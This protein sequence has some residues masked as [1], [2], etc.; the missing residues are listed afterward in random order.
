MMKKLTSGMLAAVMVFGMAGSCLTVG[1]SDAKVD[2]I[3]LKIWDSKQQDDL[4]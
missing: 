1:A 4:R 2:S 3:D